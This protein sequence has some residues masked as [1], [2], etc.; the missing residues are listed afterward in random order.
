MRPSTK[1]YCLGMS[2]LIASVQPPE[3][4]SKRS[5]VARPLLGDE[6][7]NPARPITS[8]RQAAPPRADGSES[9]VPATATGL[10]L[11]EERPMPTRRTTVLPSFAP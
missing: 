2:A 6:T 10:A 5:S 1:L 11:I 9:A 3:K 4:K 7:R 8:Q